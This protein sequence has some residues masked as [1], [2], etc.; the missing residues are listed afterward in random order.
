MVII[1]NVELGEDIEIVRELFREYQNSLGIDL[2]FQNF[3]SELAAL[4]GNYAPPDGQL[5]LAVDG[6][7]AVGCAGLRKIEAGICELKRL[8]VRPGYRGREV[9][10]RLSLRVIQDA[11]KIGYKRMRL[12]TLPSMRPALELYRS[13]GFK[14][15]SPY[16][17]NPIEGAQFLE[18]SLA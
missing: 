9:G 12:D 16:R 2:S 14:P 6:G 18:L 13:L 4:P 8:Y 10:R 11:R 5:Y 3:E 15:I 7:Q 1:R 17:N